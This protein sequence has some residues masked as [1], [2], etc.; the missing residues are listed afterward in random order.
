MEVALDKIA[1]SSPATR[2]STNR[3][4]DAGRDVPQRCV[5]QTVSTAS[6]FGG[7]FS[8]FILLHGLIMMGSGNAFINKVNVAK[9]SLADIAWGG[10]LAGA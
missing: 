2:A 10:L 8:L 6:K 3:D 5:A 9:I 4:T 7:Q 1:K